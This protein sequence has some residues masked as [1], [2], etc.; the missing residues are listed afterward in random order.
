[1]KQ[2]FLLILLVA[3]VFSC[4]NNKIKLVEGSIYITLI[5][6][7][8][9]QSLVPKD[10][11]EEF[12]SA[13]INFDTKDKSRS[14]INLNEYYRTLINNNL[15]EKPHFQL[16]LGS[17]KIINIYVGKKEYLKLK[18][19]I[20]NLDRDKEQILVK[21]KGFKV[22]NGINDRAIYSASKIVFVEKKSGKTDWH[23]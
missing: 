8:D 23:K 3:C 17:E 15:F 20:D 7:Y 5:N 12:K 22:S 18:K 14:E 9:I 16:K 19:E 11:I 2:S 1:M 4:G 6:L 13:I 10:K 21:F